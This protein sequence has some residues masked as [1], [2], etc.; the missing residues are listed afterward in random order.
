MVIDDEIDI[1]RVVRKVLEKWGFEVDAYS[2]PLYAYDVFKKNPRRYSLILTDVR[3]PEISGISL[4]VMFRKIRKDIKILVMT[5]YELTLQEINDD[6]PD[7]QPLEILSKPFQYQ[8]VCTTVKKYV[9]AH[10]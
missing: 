10:A 2:N 5:A 6:A 8:Q 3:M 9:Q 7:A 4:A 1:L